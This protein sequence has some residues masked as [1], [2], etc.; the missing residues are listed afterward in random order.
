[1]QHFES[2]II[3]L[4]NLYLQVPFRS[5]TEILPDINGR[6]VTPPLE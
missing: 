1:M 3:I 5:I 6:S 2:P 4:P